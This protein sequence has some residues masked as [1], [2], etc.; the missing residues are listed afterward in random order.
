MNCKDTFISPR[1]PAL[2]K[3][4]QLQGILWK[5]YLHTVPNVCAR[6]FPDIGKPGWYIR[7]N[8]ANYKL[9]ISLS[10]C[11]VTINNHR[12]TIIYSAKLVFVE[13][14]NCVSP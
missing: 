2:A 6:N 8:K 4:K 14:V 11:H 7:R 9:P 12:M 3:L 5:G 13:Y 10:L 1:C